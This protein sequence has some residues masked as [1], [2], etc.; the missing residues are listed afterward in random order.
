MLISGPS[1]MNLD[2]NGL[3]MDTSLDVVSD[4]GFQILKITHLIIAPHGVSNVKP[5]LPQCR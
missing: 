3:V 1:G 4:A 2:S 5:P